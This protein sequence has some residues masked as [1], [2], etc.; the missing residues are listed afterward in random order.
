MDSHDDDLIARVRAGDGEAF[1]SLVDRHAR[2]LRA[3]VAL[4]AP[5]PHLIDEIAHEAFVHAYRHLDDFTGGDLA[6]WLR[7]IAWNKLRAEMQRHARHG[8]QLSRYAAEVLQAEG[9][10]K[11]SDAAIERLPACLDR[12][13]ATLRQL[14][15][16]RYRDGMSA[17]L[18]AERLGRSAEWIRTN[19]YRTR[20][21]LRACLDGTE[22]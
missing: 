17:D 9:P 11:E 3:F 8:E 6:A 13:P 7:A 4:R 10:D 21:R 20:N 22:A 19:L 2:R 15:D 14:I 18:M 16:W 1:G 5:V 12:L